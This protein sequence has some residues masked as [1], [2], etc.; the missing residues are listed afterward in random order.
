MSQ[1]DSSYDYFL[2][3]ARSFCDYQERTLQEVKNKLKGWSIS[4]ELCNK[5]IRQLE[6]EN[7]INEERFARFYALGKLRNNHWGRNKII[8]GMRSKG[9]PELM[10]EIGLSE[11]D[12]EEYRKILQKVLESKK[13][14]EPDD[15]K[16]RTKL[17]QYAFQKGFQPQL[18][19]QLINELDL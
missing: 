13:I 9:L 7:L 4:D 2:T 8:A 17:A 15:Y 6:E 16:R 12:E 18:I 3:K 10:T 14:K 1:S 11:I 19:W 5:I